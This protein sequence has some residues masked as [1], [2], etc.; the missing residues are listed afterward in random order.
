[1]DNYRIILVKPNMRLELPDKDLDTLAKA[2]D[3][4]EIYKRKNPYPYYIIRD[5][6]LGYEFEV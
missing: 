3:R 2:V 5:V 4:V 6:K 1:M